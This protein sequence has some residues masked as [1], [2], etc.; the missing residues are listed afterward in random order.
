MHTALLFGGGI[1]LTGAVIAAALIRDEAH[2]QPA[3]S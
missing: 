1:E 3:R 2:A